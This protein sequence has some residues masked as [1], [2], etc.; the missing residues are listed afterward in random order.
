[1]YYL[2][3]IKHLLKYYISILKKDDFIEYHSF[4]FDPNNKMPNGSEKVLKDCCS[5]IKDLCINY[6]IT[7]GTILGLYRGGN[8]IDHDNDIDIDIIYDEKI[9]EIEKEF[10]NIKMT[11]G[12][13]AIYK[14]KLQQIIFYTS[15]HIVFDIVIWHLNDNDGKLYNYSERDY[16]RVQDTKYFQKDKLENIEFKGNKYPMPTP[17]EEWLEIRYGDDWKT[18]KTYK[19]DWKEECFD[20]KKMD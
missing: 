5:V 9:N 8:F 19:G 15:N 12:R 16:E 13:K 17:I 3:K 14:G 6:R 7:D 11:L 1:M 20:M 10:K 18:P 2:K 4:P